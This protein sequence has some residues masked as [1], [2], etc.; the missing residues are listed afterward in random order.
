MVAGHWASANIQSARVVIIA[1]LLTCLATHGSVANSGGAQISGTETGAGDEGIHARVRRCVVLAAVCC[2]VILIVAVYGGDD[3]RA[4]AAALWVAVVAVVAQYGFEQALRNAGGDAAGV[5]GAQVVIIANH[6]CTRAY[7]SRRVA[8][9][10]VA[11]IGG[12]A[13]VRGE[14]A[15][16]NS[17]GGNTGVSSTIVVVIAHNRRSRACTGGGVAC[18]WVAWVYWARIGLEL[19]L[20]FAGGNNATVICASVVI[21]ANNWENVTVACGS[22]ASLRVAQIRFAARFGSVVAHALAGEGIT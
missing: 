14:G 13:R 20:S 2:A 6:G 12:G 3:A 16:G 19:A 4:V 22:I 10:G 18:L 7:T 17:V 5:V 15:V 8:A 1:D 9:V 21:I 11:Q